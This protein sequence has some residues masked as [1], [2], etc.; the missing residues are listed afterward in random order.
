MDENISELPMI[1]CSVYYYFFL[2]N[3]FSLNIPFWLSV[4]F[5]VRLTLYFVVQIVHLFISTLLWCVYI[6]HANADTSS[7]TKKVTIDVNGMA[8]RSVLNGYR[9][10]DLGPVETFLNIIIKPNSLCLKSGLG[11]GI[12]VGQCK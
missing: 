3:F 2:S 11:L 4:F 1:T 10:T 5:W 8:L 6:A 7:C 9:S 12:G